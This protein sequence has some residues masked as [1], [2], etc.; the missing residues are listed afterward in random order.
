MERGGVGKRR[1]EGRGPSMLLL[2]RGGAL[3]LQAHDQQVWTFIAIQKEKGR[4][5]EKKEVVF[6]EKK[7]G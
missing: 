3:H 2:H 5:E 1:E 6:C 4:K 7:K